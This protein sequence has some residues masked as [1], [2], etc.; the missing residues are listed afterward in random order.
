MIKCPDKIN[1]YFHELAPQPP[2]PGTMINPAICTGITG[3]LVGIG[4]GIGFGALIFNPYRAGKVGGGI[5]FGKR[6]RKRSLISGE[7]DDDDYEEF[8]NV[9]DK[10]MSD[11]DDAKDLYDDIEDDVELE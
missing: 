2:V 3:L 8:F 7:D 1:C 4:I 10:I 6:R 5:W 9:Q 11:I